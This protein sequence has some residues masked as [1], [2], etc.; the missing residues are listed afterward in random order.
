MIERKLLT[1]GPLAFLSFVLSFLAFAAIQ[2]GYSHTLNMIS[3][4]GMAGAPN[5]LAWNL[6]GFGLTGLLALVFAWG[7]R[8]ALPPAGG[9][10]AVAVLVAIAGAGW[11]ALGLFPAA[12]GFQPSVATTLHFSAVAVNYVAFLASCVV[13]AVSL[14]R[15]PYWQRWVPLAIVMAAL[16]F[17]SFFIP[18]GLL[19]PGLSQR[20]ALLVYF[21]WLLG[22]GWAALRKPRNIVADKT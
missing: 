6:I 14:R 4:L 21:V 20:L 17:A 12:R 18:P 9:A 10:T 3:E 5:A 22:L 11:T 2:P 16:G 1:L 13:F 19:S 7:L 8:A 15:E